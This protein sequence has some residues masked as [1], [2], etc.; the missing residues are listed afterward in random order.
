MLY[1]MKI[2]TWSFALFMIMTAAVFADDDPYDDSRMWKGEVK[3][4]YSRI[5]H[6]EGSNTDNPQVTAQTMYDEQFEASV[7]IG[8]CVNGGVYAWIES[9][10]FHFSRTDQASWQRDHKACL[11]D[12]RKSSWIA[13][14]G[15]SFEAEEIVTGELD[16]SAEPQIMLSL[17]AWPDGSYTLTAGGGYPY[18]ITQHS[19]EASTEA[20]SGE[21]E[22]TTS[23]ITPGLEEDAGGTSAEGGET[24]LRGTLP[25][26]PMP[27]IVAYR[28]IVE[29]DEIKGDT[30][31]GQTEDAASHKKYGKEINEGSGE[32]HETMTASWHFKAVEP[33]DQVMEQLRKSMAFL[34]A[35]NDVTLLNS[36]LDGDAYDEEIGKLA[37][38][39]YGQSG[40]SGQGQGQKEYEA[41]TDLGVN[42]NCELVG[43]NAFRDSEQKACMPDIVVDA[44]ITH[45]MTHV[46]QCTNS[47]A[48]FTRGFHDPLIQ[49]KYEIEAYCTEIN[50]LLNWLDDNC[51]NDLSEHKDMVNSICQ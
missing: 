2:F 38:K 32:W 42:K 3:I 34:A 43:E 23:I 19:V 28:G 16:M 30:V 9:N 48:L 14:P 13:R 20:C 29:E 50:M 26:V 31:F 21:T 5:G 4:T 6:Y 12:D 11:S 7:T 36:G 46:G 8:A 41:T 40:G 25:P 17:V 39:I 27:L 18:L 47:K 33:C 37:G 24:M 15:D 45:E 44:I 1:S 10:D 49:S 22:K 51:E 35:Y